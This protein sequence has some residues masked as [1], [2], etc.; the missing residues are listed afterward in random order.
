[1]HRKGLSP[2]GHSKSMATQA[3]MYFQ[4]LILAVSSI[5]ESE[6]NRRLYS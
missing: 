4:S 5:Y 3:Y 2:K 1:M 6:I